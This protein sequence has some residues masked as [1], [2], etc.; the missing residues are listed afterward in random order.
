M[1][2][3]PVKDSNRAPRS[4]N[5]D[6]VYSALSMSLLEPVDSPKLLLNYSLLYT[7]K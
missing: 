1:R 5:I 3:A 7:P 4:S 2:T 6:H